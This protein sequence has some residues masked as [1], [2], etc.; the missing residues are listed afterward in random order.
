[1]M[2]QRVCAV[3]VTYYPD[4]SRL[5]N[6]LVALEEQVDQICIVNNSKKSLPLDQAKQIAIPITVLDNV[7]NVGIGRAHNQG[8]DVAVAQGCSHVLL[9]DQDSLP[10]SDMVSCL[11]QCECKALSQGRRVG[12]VGPQVVDAESGSPEPLFR[13]R[14]WWVSRLG[15]GEKRCCEVAYLIASGT[16]LRTEIFPLVGHFAEEL[17]IDL[18]DVEWGFRAHQ[19]GFSL[20]VCCNAQLQH[21]IGVKESFLA[22]TAVTRHA[23]VRLYYQFRNYFFL[24]RKYFS[25]FSGWFIYHA[26]RRLLPRFF[27]FLLIPPRRQHAAMM[28]RGVWDGLS[29]NAPPPPNTSIHE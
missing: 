21:T 14:R 18:V 19:K 11:I 20:L 24:L 16:L 3:I 5:H 6:L 28:L 1:M 8:I 26:I 13:A 27:L 12:A 4:G 22:G 2:P 7:D 10:G 15:C 23:P 29:G 9:L 17:F 25:S